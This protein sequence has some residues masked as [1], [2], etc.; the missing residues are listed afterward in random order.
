MELSD[1]PRNDMPHLNI[2]HA[3]NNGIISLFSYICLV[4][5]WL[6]LYLAIHFKDCSLDLFC[7]INSWLT[8]PAYSKR[9]PDGWTPTVKDSLHFCIQLIQTSHLHQQFRKSCVFH[10]CL[11]KYSTGKHDFDSRHFQPTLRYHRTV[12]DHLFPHEETCDA[13]GTRGEW[14]T[15]CV[16]QQNDNK[17]AE[18]MCKRE[19]KSQYSTKPKFFHGK[20]WTVRLSNDAS[21]Y[22]LGNFQKLELMIV[23]YF[24]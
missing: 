17:W 22:W 12:D 3:F 21:S 18:E 6:S 23:Q 9:G 24:N 5:I 13:K 19:Y 8:P 20:R 2:C 7:V 10:L 11:G 14:W 1:S 15:C 16:S 4:I